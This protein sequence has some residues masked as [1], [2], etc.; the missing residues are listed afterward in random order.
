MK[1][2]D[3]GSIPMRYLETSV[4]LSL[5]L[6]P[7]QAGVCSYRT[8][9]WCGKAVTS[10]P[11]GAGI[12]CWLEC[13]TRDR[14]VASSNP[15]RSGGRIFFSRVNFMCWL[16][17]GVRSTPVLPQWHVKNL[18]HSVKSA[19]GRLH[20][21]THTPLIQRSRNGLTMP[22]FR[23]SV[24]THQETSSHA[25]YQGTVGH[26]RLSSLSHCGLILAG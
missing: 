8:T 16:L 24:G 12:A 4:I 5:S 15:G 2:F 1:C 9:R 13:R 11:A 20:L 14:K 7:L 25:T 3:N 18:G 19:G 17:F 22:L 26:S 23:H 6:V 21:N 10:V